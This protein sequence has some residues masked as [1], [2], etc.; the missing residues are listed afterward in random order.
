MNFKRQLNEV[1]EDKGE[2]EIE[3]KFSLPPS[4]SFEVMISSMDVTA[5]SKPVIS[6]ISYHYNSF[7]QM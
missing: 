1:F 4:E 2:V 6:Y 7:K 3:M 5:N